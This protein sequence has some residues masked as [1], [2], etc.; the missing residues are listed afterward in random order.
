MEQNASAARGRSAVEEA[1]IEA[2]A[3]LL[4]EMGPTRVSLRDIANR[5]GVNKGQIHHYFGGKQPLIEAAFRRVA[6]EH[7]HNAQ[8]RGGGGLPVPLTLGL[9]QRYL[10]A[11]VRIVLDGDLDTARLEFD[12][13]ISIPR[14]ALAQLTEITGLEEPDRQLKAEFAAVMAMELGW[15]AFAPFIQ[16]AVEADDPADVEDIIAR[17]RSQAAATLS[18][19]SERGDTG[20]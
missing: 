18:M 14:A 10:Q 19:I 12:E 7:F 3:D 15:A 17:L 2:A 5:A 4:A 16:M 9:D 1:L 20:G 11:V 13:N 6:T 8:Q